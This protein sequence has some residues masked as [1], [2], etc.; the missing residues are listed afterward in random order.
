[1]TETADLPKSRIGFWGGIGKEK[2]NQAP[3]E[4]PAFSPD[5]FP[6]EQNQSYSRFLV[7]GDSGVGKTTWCQRWIDAVLADGWRVGGL[8]SPPVMVD[9][10]K[11]A[12]DLVD[13]ASGERRPLAR[14]R[15]S[16]ASP[17]TVTTGK[18]L[19]DTAV[20]RWGNDV[21]RRITAV[22]L[23]IIDELG[24]LEFERGQGL[25]AAFELVAA[26]DYRMAGVV[27]RPSLI[28]QAQQRWP[29]SQPIPIERKDA[30]FHD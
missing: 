15:P 23:L 5:R 26:G 27:I 8:L 24:P 1:M 19:F 16:D 7:T 6:H 2:M 29:A 12:I 18:W 11:V 4:W 10:Q 21:L 13:L 17:D 30:D 22:D 14:L 25:Q 3:S 28:S 20:L 9:G